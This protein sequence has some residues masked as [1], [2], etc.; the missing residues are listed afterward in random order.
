MYNTE[1]HI[2]I[3]FFLDYLKKDCQAIS[4]YQQSYDGIGR[5][6][7]IYSVTVKKKIDVKLTARKRTI[8][9]PF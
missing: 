5:V 1:T 2:K 3:G 7:D 6:N 4:N 8:L 9:I